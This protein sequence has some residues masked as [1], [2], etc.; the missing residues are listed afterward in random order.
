MGIYPIFR[1]THMCIYIYIYIPFIF[2][3]YS[4]HIIFLEIII[5]NKNLL[6]RRRRRSSAPATTR[7]HS[8][9]RRPKSEA[10]GLWQTAA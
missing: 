6:G 8:S 10:R 3:L 5:P 4:L 1:Q 2:P 7:V 9:L